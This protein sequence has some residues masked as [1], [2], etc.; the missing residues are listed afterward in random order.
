MSVDESALRKTPLGVRA[1]SQECL[2]YKK[3]K[4]IVRDQPGPADP[5]GMCS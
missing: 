1:F 3:L 5:S 2:P 4:K